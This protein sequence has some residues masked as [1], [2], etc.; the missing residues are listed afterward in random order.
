[1]LDESGLLGRLADEFTRRIREGQNPEPDEY[2]Q[3][4]PELAERI[5]GLFPTLMVLERMAA[6]EARPAGGESE[7]ADHFEPPVL[8]LPPGTVFGSYRIE[9]KLGQGA[10][11]VVYQAVHVPLDK[12]VALKLLLAADWGGSSHLERFFREAKTAAALHHTNIVPVFDI[13]LAGGTP[14]YA[15]QY[16]E[17]KGLD[18]VLRE[19]EAGTK[20]C[21]PPTD[22]GTTTGGRCPEAASSAEPEGLPGSGANPLTA[23]T[24]D[25]E[26]YFR[27][28][29]ELMAQAA[30]GLAHAHQ[31]GVIHRDIKPSNLLLDRQGVLWI[32]DFGLARRAA[33]PALTRS[34]VLVGTPRY[35]SPEQAEAARKTIDHRTDIYSLGATLYE[36][37]TR[38]PAV[39]GQTP[40]EVF[41][42]IIVREPI[43]PRRLD[44]RVPR[45]LETICMKCLQKDPARRY[46]TAQDLAE[47]L[48][49]FLTREPIQA[50]RIGAAERLWRWCRRNPRLAGLSAASALLLAAVALV[51]VVAAVRIAAARDD[52]EESA[53]AARRA[54]KKA[55]QNE[56]AAQRARKRIAEQAAAS[57]ERL[58][59]QYALTG[60]RAMEA[61]DLTG[62]LLWYVKALELAHSDG[63]PEDIHRIR[64]AA[65]LKECPRLVRCVRTRFP[66]YLVPLTLGKRL[67]VW[68]PTRD[69]ARVWDEIGEKWKSAGLPH[70]GVLGGAVLLAGKRVLTVGSQDTIRRVLTVGSQDTFRVWDIASGKPITPL[71]NPASHFLVQ[72]WI[73]ADERK[74][75]VAGPESTA[76]V[77]DTI[78]GKP[79][80]APIPAG[81]V[82]NDAAFSA[83]GGRIVTVLR[84]DHARIWS[85]RTGKPLTP[86]I[87]FDHQIRVVRFS[88]DGRLLLT[89]GR[90]DRS[91]LQR[92]RVW[93]ART[94]R[95]VTPQFGFSPRNGRSDDEEAEIQPDLFHSADQLGHGSYMLGRAGFHPGEDLASFSPD[96]RQIVTAAE[97]QVRVWD[98]RTGRPRTSVIR[99][100]GKVLGV[101]FSPDGRRVY[102]A[103]EGPANAR[104]RVQAWDTVTGLLVKSLLSYGLGAKRVWFRP[105][106]NRM[107]V[108]TGPNDWFF[109]ESVPDQWVREWDITKATSMTPPLGWGEPV[110]SAFYSHDGRI[111][112]VAGK[113]APAQAWDT[114]T[115]RPIIPSPKPEQAGVL[116]LA[117]FGQDG[118][119][120][121]TVSR[122][123]EE[124]RPRRQS[125]VELTQ[126]WDLVSGRPIAPAWQPKGRVE[127]A[128]FSPDGRHV[129]LVT[130]RKITKDKERREAQLWEIGRGWKTSFPLNSFASLRY[131]ANFSP[132]GQHLF[133]VDAKRVQLWDIQEGKPPC[134]SLL[135]PDSVSWACFMPNGLR[136]VTLTERKA[137]DED[138]EDEERDQDED[139]QD[140]KAHSLHPDPIGIG[141]QAAVYI[142]S[143]PSG[144]LLTRIRLGKDESPSVDFSPDGRYILTGS[145]STKA[146][147]WDATDGRLL[148]VLVHQV[149]PLPHPNHFVTA[150]FSP[151]GRLI[152][153]AR[154]DYNYNEA[155]WRV[156]DAVTGRPLTPAI[157]LASCVSGIAF[158]P[159]SRL[160]ITAGGSVAQAW[161][162]A[163]GL[164][165]S[166]PLKHPGELLYA[167]LGTGGR[168]LT[169]TRAGIMVRDFGPHGQSIDDLRL[170]ARLLSGRQ[171]D[172]AGSFLPIESGPLQRAWKAIR[173][174]THEIIS[175][176]RTAL[177]WHK[178]EAAEC[179]IAG[180]SSSA[181]WHL[182]RLIEAMPSE[183]S[184]YA[185]RA[186]SWIK[187][188]KWALAVENFTTAVALGAD[189]S[190]VWAGRGLAHARLGQLDK[191]IADCTKAIQLGAPESVRQVRGE[192]YAAHA[193]WKDAA[194]DFRRVIKPNGTG[195]Y[196]RCALS[197]LAAQDLKGYHDLLKTTLPT[198]LDPNATYDIFG[199]PPLWIGL[200]EP[201]PTIYVPLCIVIAERR[202]SRSDPPN[203]VDL[204]TL[205]ALLYRAGKF[206]PAIERLQQ[207]RKLK[208]TEKAA[209]IDLFL[210]MAYQRQGN[211]REAGKCFATADQWI[212]SHDSKLTWDDRLELQLLCKETRD[213][214][215]DTSKKTTK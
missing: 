45:D 132:R 40:E 25:P 143:V 90:E 107:W 144:R 141:S 26:G 32:T 82:P 162:A 14:Y 164:P 169:Q 71:L 150:S 113:F 95:P 140:E 121:L 157:R 86:L 39:P 123:V 206:G 63:R 187:S 3:R 88:P 5:R 208:G 185:R 178:A 59:K 176:R 46:T 67:Q 193:Q 15:M 146:K 211:V 156:W 20:A 77:W 28:V 106:A 2:V 201:H 126:V 215:K 41:T 42:Q 119:R 214:L 112:L 161:E 30:Q 94:G 8:N 160:V 93:D 180:H 73:S 37:L 38:R 78:T 159:D 148:R 142:W 74:L 203:R 155:D 191:A 23:P 65:V 204:V 115:G 133:A 10:M 186:E 182:D 55:K 72:S 153:T 188:A 4:H 80:S 212:K 124:L 118:H 151:N 102:T 16:I 76:Q 167:S 195:P 170:L 189:A 84:G 49:R 135:H 66:E 116:R 29:A 12:P 190:G 81:D 79:I 173:K 165:V 110:R 139:V 213:V 149:D 44:P 36:L 125:P 109:D 163:N 171:V 1:M 184:L 58:E 120:L 137:Q 62:A 54:E 210:A 57:R 52:A 114:R 24:T 70:K 21:P 145:I 31:R 48:T 22:A 103:S 111:A 18:Q 127:D 196:R 51:S 122:K 168:L 194:Q 200:L 56:R 158:S 183:G 17:G 43:T 152:L 87:T 130:S 104:L 138:D 177:A 34:G 198:M 209:A 60:V 101:A 197:F 33:D 100:P 131:L 129:L 117:V 68:I 175:T 154:V 99:L 105:E 91:Y 89:A 19:L 207:A 69:T 136:L 75:F 166:L 179:E 7:R 172:S 134:R 147:L 11:G 83:D 53:Q 97:D 205:G 174:N 50:R 98:A 96:S 92:A 47:D 61:G 181:L 199:D 9:R 6:G 202:L 35:M 64:I 27:R 192:A 108:L 85:V 13:G 128:A